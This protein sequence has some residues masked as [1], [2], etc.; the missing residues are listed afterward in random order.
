VCGRCGAPKHA[1][2]IT[3]LMQPGGQPNA[4]FGIAK[5]NTIVVRITAMTEVIT[6]DVLS[7]VIIVTRIIE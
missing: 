6:N 7:G 4:W 2:P 5:A 3:V 1:H